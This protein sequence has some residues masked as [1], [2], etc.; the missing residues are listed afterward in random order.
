M[1]NGTSD[2]NTELHQVEYF[3]SLS[4][5]R[6]RSAKVYN[7]ISY[8][9]S[10][11]FSLSEEKLDTIVANIISLI[12]RDYGTH[13][14]VP[15]HGRW[16]SFEIFENGSKR[17][18]FNEH[19]EA[20]KKSGIDNNECTRRAIDLFVIS[21]LLDA[22]AGSQWSY[23]DEK[24]N[25][26]YKRTEGLG[27]ASLRMFEAGIFSS[28]KQNPYQVDAIGLLSF[29][30]ED[31]IKG[32]QVSEKNIL[33]GAENRAALIKRLGKVLKNDNLYFK[34]ESSNSI[35]NR[36][37]NML[38]YLV[39]NSISNT[40][41]IELLWDVIIN[42]FLHVWP[43]SRTSINNSP[44]GDTWVCD[45]LKTKKLYTKPPS[46]GRIS[47]EGDESSNDSINKTNNV[48]DIN[49]EALVPFHKL[50]MWLTWSLVEALQRIG[51]LKI[52]KLNLLTG[53]PEYRNGGLFVDMGVLHLNNSYIQENA[54][55]INWN[56]DG[57]P[58][59]EVDSQLVIEWRA[60]TIVLLDKLH[61]KVIKVLQL[62]KNEFPLNK[63]LEAGSWKAGREI[64]AKLRP[65]TGNPPIG[66]ISD[67]TIF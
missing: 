44:L 51:N 1:T 49:Y 26:I 25:S 62:D 60:L 18:L 31:L 14:N 38:D 10:K 64:A 24:T 45:I 23:Q 66:I 15:A 48:Q 63:L 59:F 61:E 4:T 36:P 39:D 58:L 19:V 34:S 54:S 53:L 40:I 5:I 12:K 9:N 2:F 46:Y 21:V 56:E 7:L 37:G 47:S 65:S 52:E 67:G 22:G 30:D 43:E 13:N 16:R 17:D 11:H 55:T 33:I 35:S 57:T 6:E 29:T 32:F 42:G 50:S 3:R 8:G 20:W 41:D 28:N 27:I